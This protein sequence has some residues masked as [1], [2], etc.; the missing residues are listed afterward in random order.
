MEVTLKPERHPRAGSLEIVKNLATYNVNDPAVFVFQIEA[1]KDG[2]NVYSDVV[3]MVFTGA[4]QKKVVL[5]KIPAGAT[6]KVTEIYSGASYEVTSAAEQTVTVSAE[7]VVSVEFHN[8]H[9]TTNHG[10]GG[11][12]NHFT[13]DAEDGWQLEQQPANRTVGE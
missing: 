2:E 3:T 4:G 10:G 9:S 5:D 13:Y 1:E 7:A 8:D 11:V 12:N 6:V